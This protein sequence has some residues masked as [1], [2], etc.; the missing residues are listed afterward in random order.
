MRVL[1]CGNFIVAQRDPVFALIRQSVIQKDFF[2]GNY[3]TREDVKDGQIQYYV[4]LNY[5]LN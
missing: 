2:F 5:S 3:L 1:G 4:V